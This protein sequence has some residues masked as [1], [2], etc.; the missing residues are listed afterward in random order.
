MTGKSGNSTSIGDSTKKTQ[1]RKSWFG[2]EREKRKVAVRVILSA[3]RDLNSKEN[4]IRRDAALF[5][6]GK[7][8]HYWCERCGIDRKR[9]NL[10]L[11]EIVS[12]PV[13][14]RRRRLIGDL[15]EELQED[16]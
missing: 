13:G 7:D 9:L 3:I 2:G 12:Q 6:S 8:Y 11:K 5:I 4:K 14:V 15:L 1:E 16:S 10:A